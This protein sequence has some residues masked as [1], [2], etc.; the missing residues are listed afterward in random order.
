MK[1]QRNAAPI[2][3]VRLHLSY[4]FRDRHVPAG[5]L[6]QRTFPGQTRLFF[7]PTVN[8]HALILVYPV[9]IAGILFLPLGPPRAKHSTSIAAI[10]GSLFAFFASETYHLTNPAALKNEPPLVLVID[11]FRGIVP[12]S[13]VVSVHFGYIHVPQG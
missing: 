1:T 9:F 2:R 12:C 8:P 11:T 13:V 10:F 6:H 5:P 3:I 4:L 7:R